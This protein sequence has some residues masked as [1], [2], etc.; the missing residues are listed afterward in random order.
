MGTTRLRLPVV[1]AVV[2]LSCSAAMAQL[3]TA[4]PPHPPFADVVKEY[5]RLG[6]PLPPPDAELVRINISQ[7]YQDENDERPRLHE[8]YLLGFKLAPTRLGADPRYLIGDGRIWS[9]AWFDPR[10]VKRVEPTPNALDQFSRDGIECLCLAVQCELRGWHDLAR[11]AY[12]LAHQQFV[13]EGRE[14][15]IIDELHNS[16][17]RL[18]ARRLGERGTDRKEVLQHLKQLAS[19]DGSLKRPDMGGFL[20]RLESTV[21]GPFSKP[22]T[23]EA[24]IDALTD[25]WNDTEDESNR[26]GQEAYWELAELGFEAVPALIDHVSDGRFTRGWSHGFNFRSAHDLTVGHLCS[27]LLF[28]LSGRSIGGNYWELR[29][30]YLDPGKAREW[31]AAAKK[32]GEEKWLLD[33]AMPKGGGPKIGDPP[34]T[35][36]NHIIRVIGAKYPDRLPAIYRAMISRPSINIVEELVAS[37]LPHQKK[38]ALLEEGVT[39]ENPGHRRDALEGLA[40]V[41]KATFHKHLLKFIQEDRADLSLLE[42]AD[43]PECWI[44]FASAIKRQPFEKRMTAIRAVGS[45]DPPDKVDPIRRGRLVFLMR[46]L[47]DQTTEKLDD[48]EAWSMVEVR[49]FAAT[50]LAG[51]LRFHVKRTHGDYMVEHDR[52]LGPISRLI[53]REAVRQA[54]EK[55]LARLGK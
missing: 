34:R 7:T 20:D 38:L 28:D 18:W 26:V 45:L 24:R 32:I 39:T 22:G 13:L 36:H 47:D 2:L 8:S 30:D 27:R 52:N 17:W 15:S 10:T 12:A 3:P 1:S 46:F 25:Y 53:F 50:H 37:R 11:A 31:F 21:R 40:E 4:P 14:F 5:Q 48:D 49:D 55:E 33:H 42:K 44:A 6:L 54:A 23:V 35:P 51:L 9:N 29:G 16:T 41:D 43:S 19:E